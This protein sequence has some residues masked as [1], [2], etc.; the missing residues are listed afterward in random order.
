MEG[1]E[2][3]DDQVDGSRIESFT[4]RNV[5]FFAQRPVFGGKP[6]SVDPSDPL[7]KAQ[8]S[9]SIDSNTNMYHSDQADPDA[10]DDD[11]DDLYS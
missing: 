7:Y 5:N 3:Y 4:K 8:L 1:E 6:L 10:K 11:E 9:G 2:R